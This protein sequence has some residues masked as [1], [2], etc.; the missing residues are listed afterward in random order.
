MT[1]STIKITSLPPANNIT[2]N[3]IFPMSMSSSGDQTFKVTLGQLRNTLNFEDAFDSISAGLVATEINE[4]FYVF[5]DVTKE[6]VLAFLNTGSGATAILDENNVQIGYVTGKRLNDVATL[7]DMASSVPGLGASLLTTESGLS[8]QEVVSLGRIVYPEMFGINLTNPTDDDLWS[9]MFTALD[10]LSD[11]ALSNDL[12]YTIDLR[13]NV[14]TL[15]QAHALDINFNIV[16]GVLLMNGGSIMMGDESSNAKTRRHILKDLKVRY[17]G[18]TYFPDALIKMARAY[19]SFSINCDFWPGVSTTLETT[20]TYI[21]KPQRA[22]YGLW[23]GSKRAWG[24][25]IISGEYYG[26]EIACRIG[27]T[28]DHTGLTVTGGATFHHGWVGNL[29]LCNPAGFSIAGVNIEHSENGAWGLCITSGTNADLG[30]INPAH[31]G[32]ISGV[33]FYNN[34]NGTTGTTNTP[35]GVI[36]GYDAPGTMDFDVAGALITSQNTAHSISVKNCYIVSPKQ[37]W[38][39]KMR[40]LSGLEV[41][42]NKYTYATGSY[43]II[44]EGTAARS[45]GIDNRNQSTGIFDEVEYTSSSKPRVGVRSGT[46]LPQLVGANVAGSIVYSTRGADYSIGNGVCNLSL[47]L[48]VGSVTTQPDGALTI[49]LPTAITAGRRSGC[50]VFA[51]ALVAGNSALPV[52]AAI[53]NGTTLSLYLSGASM[54]GAVIQATT[55]IRLSISYPIDGAVYTGS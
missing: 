47:W 40:G 50:G 51:L 21:G 6:K 18:T 33:Y 52:T 14:Y 27:Y 10:N 15:T 20:G 2:G 19:N 53:T 23:M 42:N 35:A 30:V 5:T 36:I 17:I 28:N 34:G 43:G 26:G 37:D 9:T 1:N 32:E 49:A 25:G 7:S 29:L 45:D 39:V 4:P 3:A 55:D 8:V 13:G 31:G 44:F 41:R 38:A 24:C 16:N 12:P 54:Q 22:R 48:T 46:F 11:T